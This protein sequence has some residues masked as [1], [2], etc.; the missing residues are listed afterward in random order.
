MQ[1]YWYSYEGCVVSQATNTTGKGTGKG[2]SAVCPVG[3]LAGLTYGP[4][5]QPAFRS[6]GNIVGPCGVGYDNF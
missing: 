2:V 5:V 6:T 1:A 3:T 4:D